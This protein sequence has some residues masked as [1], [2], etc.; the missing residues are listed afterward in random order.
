MRDVSTREPAT[1]GVALGDASAYDLFLAALPLPLVA[2][3]LA[4][5][6]LSLP[7]AFGAGVGSLPAAAMLIYGLFVRSPADPIG[8]V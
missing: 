3:V 6:T 4:A 5:A 7:V 1:D 8:S 2:G